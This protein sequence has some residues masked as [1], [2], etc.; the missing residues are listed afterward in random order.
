MQL[1]IIDRKYNLDLLMLIKI[2]VDETKL[3]YRSTKKNQF[4]VHV[5]YIVNSICI[6]FA[7]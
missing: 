7:D 3:K 2:G 5:I 1:T 6:C 4:A